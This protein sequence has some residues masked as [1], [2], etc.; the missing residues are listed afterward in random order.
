MEHVFG[1]ALAAVIVAAVALTI[2]Q[3]MFAGPGN[4]QKAGTPQYKCLECGYV[5]EQEQIP[6]DRMR[7]AIDPALVL[8][9]CPDCGAERSAMQMIRCPDCGEYYISQRSLYQVEHNGRPAPED[10]RDVCPE[11]GTDRLQYAREHR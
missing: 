4:V 1:G 10:V 2:W 8:L 11:C 3:T 7:E 6:R 9:D 5:F